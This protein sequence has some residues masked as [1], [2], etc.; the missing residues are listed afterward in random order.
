MS[1]QRNGGEAIRYV[2]IEWD[3]QSG[4]DST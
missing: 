2:N 4:A 3:Q 1:D